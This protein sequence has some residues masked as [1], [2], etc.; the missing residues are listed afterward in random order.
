M[1][2]AR[3]IINIGDHL[4]PRNKGFFKGFF[5]EAVKQSGPS[6]GEGNKFAEQ[7]TLGGVNDSGPSPGKGH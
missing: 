3:P 7:R 2:K 1:T 5:W 4:R 6:P